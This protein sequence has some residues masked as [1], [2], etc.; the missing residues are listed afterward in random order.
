MTPEQELELAEAE[1]AA[2]DQPD[3]IAPDSPLAKAA[4]EQTGDVLEIQTPTGP[5][6]GTREG[7]PVLSAEEATAHMDP[8]LK[9]RRLQ[10][11][12]S[13]AQGA[14]LGLAGP[15]AGANAVKDRLREYIG[16]KLTGEQAAP[17]GDTYQK[18]ADS[19]RASLNEAT[20]EG[21][22]TVRIPFTQAEL[23]VLPMVG[24]MATMSP[25][26]AASGA[27]S[28][29]LGMG[30][31]GGLQ[32]AGESDFDPA[33]T[34][35]GALA[36]M[37]VAAP[38]EAAGGLA[39]YLAKRAGLKS[40]AAHVADIGQDLSKAEKAKASAL[41]SVGSIGAQQQNALT[42]YDDVL[43]GRIKV[44]PEV[45]ERAQSVDPAML[46]SLR[47]RAAMNAIERLGRLAPAEDAARAELAQAV[48]FA[49]PEAAAA[50]SG[51][52]IASAYTDQAQK[53]VSSVAPRVAT[54]L[55]ADVLGTG[56]AVGLTSPGTQQ[57]RRNAMANKAL[58][59]RFW[60]GVSSE[61]GLQ[62]EALQEAGRGAALNQSRAVDSL[63][64]Y[65]GRPAKKDEA[66]KI[67][68]Q[69]GNADPQYQDR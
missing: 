48:E 44:S 39:G 7:V 26:G 12:A 2:V 51:E 37:A 11:I 60:G 1:A 25:I 57:M 61:M 46:Q 40:R 13:L 23:P 29:M 67:H 42:W 31:T 6:R 8:L 17:L 33:D 21:S 4:A 28:R 65:L 27:A 20:R 69:A 16:K 9:E 10:G 32:S 64:E 52:R 18:A 58:G 63:S 5:W 59:A 43:S 62:S 45:L 38:F 14:S 47:D 68:F 50:R 19:T 15:V 3:A 22:P 66:A 34:A 56:S 35:T 49:K 41:G 30:Y 24:G 54:G 55:A 36:S 53:V